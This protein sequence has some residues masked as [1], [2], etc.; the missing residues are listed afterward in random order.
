VLRP[1]ARTRPQ[2]TIHCQ[3]VAIAHL[4]RA[5]RYIVRPKIEGAAAFEIEAG[6][7]PMLLYM[8]EPAFTFAPDHASHAIVFRR[9]PLRGR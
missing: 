8:T 5:D 3:T 7:V 4:D 6:V 1:P 2:P 9:K